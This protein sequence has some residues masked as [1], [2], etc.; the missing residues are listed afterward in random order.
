MIFELADDKMKYRDQKFI[1]LYLI[2]LSISNNPSNH[3]ATIQ[4]DSNPSIHSE[5]PSNHIETIATTKQSL[6]TP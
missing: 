6:K 1:F 2:L 5:H 3:I 4:L